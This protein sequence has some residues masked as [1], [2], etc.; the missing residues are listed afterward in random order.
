MSSVFYYSEDICSR[1]W[2]WPLRRGILPGGS[3]A[4]SD[5]SPFRHCPPRGLTGRPA[6][7]PPPGRGTT[8]RRCS[9]FFSALPA[10]PVQ[11][12]PILVPGKESIGGTFTREM[13]VE[14]RDSGGACSGTDDIGTLPYSQKKKIF[15]EVVE[16]LSWGSPVGISLF[17]FFSGTGAGVFFWGVSQF[18]NSNKGDEDERI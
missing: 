15:M 1:R 4:G 8:R 6:S 13:Q 18:V 12:M 9:L 5:A 17:F 14:F 7:S 11:R 3:T 10:S 2:T 16:A